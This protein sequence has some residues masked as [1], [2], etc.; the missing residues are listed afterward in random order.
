MTERTM[1]A[2]VERLHAEES[3]AARELEALSRGL[4]ELERFVEALDRAMKRIH[5]EITQWV[6]EEESGTRLA[7]LLVLESKC[8][9][10]SIASGQ[11]VWEV[12]AISDT[13]GQWG[14]GEARH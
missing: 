7:T 5:A 11:I 3:E 12:K 1:R 14:L 13:L 2:V 8:E 6:A 10:A 9:L 4:S